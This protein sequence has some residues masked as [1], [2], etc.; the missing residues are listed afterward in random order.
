MYTNKNVKLGIKIVNSFPK[1]YLLLLILFANE[2]CHDKPFSCFY[3]R[4]VSKAKNGKKFRAERK[5]L[6][7]KEDVRRRSEEL[8]KLQQEIERSRRS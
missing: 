1:M 7:G 3:V 8:E 5:E 4:F 6:D 2:K